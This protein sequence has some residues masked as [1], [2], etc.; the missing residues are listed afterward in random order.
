[1][2]S[3]LSSRHRIKENKAALLLHSMSPV[4][5]QTR[6]TISEMPTTK[7]TATTTTSRLRTSS[8]AASVT[9]AGTT[10]TTSTAVRQTNNN[11]GHSEKENTKALAT[12][13][14]EEEDDNDDDDDAYDDDEDDDE[15][16]AVEPIRQAVPYAQ[17]L[18]RDPSLRNVSPYELRYPGWKQPSWNKKKKACRQGQERIPPGKHVCF[19]HVGKTAG[20]TVGCALGFRL[21]CDDDATPRHV[22]SRLP[23]TLPLYTTNMLHSDVND[24]PDGMPFH[25]FVVRNP[26][27]RAAS[28]YIYDRDTEGDDGEY[29]LYVECKFWTLAQLAAGGLDVLEA[30][31]P[32][33]GTRTTEVCRK[34]ARDALTG[35]VQYGE[36]LYY[37]YQYYLEEAQ[38][39][40]VLVIR[41][42]HILADW[43]SAQRV[44]DKDKT[45]HEP[46]GSNNAAA[47]S[48]VVSAN[49]F[50]PKNVG[51]KTDQDRPLTDR[52][53]RLVCQVLCRE[54]QAYKSILRQAINIKYT[55]V[56]VS[57][58]ELAESCP[59][60]AILDD[61]TACIV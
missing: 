50:R 58:Q 60:E 53:R 13:G 52:E 5:I 27:H 9:T 42:E 45:H 44:V 32:T 18:A 39:K 1:M 12:T 61:V 10:P 21:H 48:L 30:H 17:V 54:I 11:A 43:I 46:D 23:G 55:D 37:N 36:H 8:K 51:S 29:E 47:S 15:V 57:I 20:S 3:A 59:E 41:S 56:E 40:Q 28:A 26:F 16:P 14:N 2:V 4:A 24:C 38:A 33:N 49:D 31:N 25:L 22:D 19:V 7:A 34:R 35:N 6:E